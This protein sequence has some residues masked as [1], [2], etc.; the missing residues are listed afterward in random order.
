MLGTA[1]HY[2]DGMETQIGAQQFDRMD[3][4]GADFSDFIPQDM[5]L[6]PFGIGGDS[7]IFTQSLDLE[8]LHMPFQMETVQIHQAL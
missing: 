7:N 1:P 6:V 8:F 3:L 5:D 2:Y 4:P